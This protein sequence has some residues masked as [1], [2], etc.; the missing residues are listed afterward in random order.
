MLYR[1]L[2]DATAVIHLLFVLFVA[3]GGLFVLRWRKIVWLHVPAAVWGTLV[4]VMNWICPLTT[5]EESFRI[6]AGMSGY[7]EGFL[8]HYIYRLIYPP[9]LTRG[10]QLAIAAFVLAVN[11]SVYTILIVRIGHRRGSRAS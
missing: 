6:R 2:A 11:V 9:G 10:V 8:A 1:F 7:S 4:E 3:L 5:W